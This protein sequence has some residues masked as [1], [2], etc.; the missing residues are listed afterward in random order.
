MCGIAGLYTPPHEHA[1]PHELLA[2]AGELTH[3]GP[4]GVGLYLDD[5]FGMTATRLAIVDLDGGT[6]P[7]ANETR[8][9]W[10]MQNGEIYD[11]VERRAE[12]TALGHTFTT[13]SD[14]EVIVHAY[15]QWGDGFL[16]HLNG[17][18][19][20]ALWDRETRELLLARDRFG[21]RPLYLSKQN[22]VTRF[23][24]EPA[25]LLRHARATRALDPTALVDTF[26]LWAP[27][28]G[29]SAYT[30]IEELPPATLQ[31]IGPDG[32]H[33]PRT[34]WTLDFAP[35]EGRNHAHQ[36]VLAEE[37]LHLLDDAT[38][39]RL[40]AD[41]PVGVYLSGGLDSS[42]TSALAQRHASQPLRAFGVG[43]DDDRFD[44][45]GHQD[46]MATAIGVDL[47]RVT[48]RDA[49]VA[50]HFPEVVER[51]A[52]PLLRTAPAPMW[53]LARL[54][55]DHGRNVVL[56]GEGADELLGGYGIFQEAM[57]RRFWA[58]QPDSRLRPALLTRIYPYLARDLASSG[59]FL[60][61]FFAQGLE[62][63]ND[64]LF[65]H[66]PRIASSR[67]NL[68]FLHPD[69]REA[70]RVHGTPEQRLLA[71]LPRDFERFG[72]LGQVQW[73]EIDTFLTTYLLH[74]QGDRMLMAHGVEGRFPFLDVRL[75]EFAA[76]LPER[77]RLADLREKALLRKAVTGLLP[78]DVA[79]RPKRPYRAPILRPFF[80][81]GAPDWVDAL[82]DP[83]TLADAGLFDV[84][85]VSQLA[86]KCRSHAASGV[87]ERDEMAL[88]G[89][90]STMLL[91]ERTVRKPN[92]AAPAE[93]TRVVIGDRVTR[94]AAPTRQG[95]LT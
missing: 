73:T 95:S 19:A 9:Y 2:M 32:V 15:E 77:A 28:R 51:T 68:R 84:D 90:L 55:H 59:G 8:R 79:Q 20:L 74:A 65:G 24:S 41:V 17:D 80:G 57:V 86:A 87:S 26:T 53:H 35:R 21:V 71:R 92:P 52:M 10:V 18:F 42:T 64:P 76:N 33:A 47:T 75:A 25:A 29:S 37:L 16:D 46:A 23:A 85:R 1:N 49:D 56:T 67:P 78:R 91:H 61:A 62:E 13:Q 44:E 34:W 58:R 82:L 54:A 60:L 88:V 22:G 70:A 72:P 63:P 48:M 7:I 89:V 94:D 27:Q 93:A 69:V 81:P 39:I 11:H 38:R 12:L 30:G 50:M 43:F 4:D 40:R 66:R 83:Y 45:T 5:R 6:P 3:R 36:D 31:R 14:T